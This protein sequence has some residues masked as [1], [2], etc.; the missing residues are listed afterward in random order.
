M[1]NG[2]NILHYSFFIVPCTF[3]RHANYS[4]NRHAN[5]SLLIINYQFP[6][7]CACRSANLE[8]IYTRSK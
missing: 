3:N 4:L 7:F 1:N 2:A 5:Y 6:R 8:H